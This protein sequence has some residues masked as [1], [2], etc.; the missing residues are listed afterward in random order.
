MTLSVTKKHLREHWI[1]IACAVLAAV[2]IVSPIIAFRFDPS[3]QGIEFFGT[4][5]ELNYVAQVH[6]IYNGNFKFGNVFFYEGQD[7]PYIRQS[8]PAILTAVVG[9]VL[10]LNVPQAIVVAKVVFPFITFLL[11]Y[12]LVFVLTRRRDAS[13]LG[14][15]FV[16]LSPATTALLD[17]KVWLPLISH[18]A[19]PGSDPQFLHYAR[20]INPQVSN[21]FFF[22]YLLTIFSLWY[23]NATQT[24]RR[25]II[26][27]AVATLILGLSFYTYLFTFTLL[28]A[29]SGI[30]WLIFLLRR[31]WQKLVDLTLIGTGGL[32]IGIP[33]YI[34][35][36]QAVHSTHWADLS[37]RVGQLL[38]HQPLISRVTLGVAALF[39]LLHRKLDAFGIFTVALLA[40]VFLV[41]NQQIITGRSIPIPQHYHWY[42]MAPLAGFILINLLYTR[43]QNLRHLYRHVLTIL[44]LVVFIGVA[45]AFQAWSYRMQQAQFV[46]IQPYGPALS[47]LGKHTTKED[48]VF[49]QEKLADLVVGY[50]PSNIYYGG[51]A[52]EFLVP[53]ERLKNAFFAYM[54]LDGV[55]AQ[56]AD[57]YFA[58]QANQTRFSNRIFGNYYPAKA[59]CYACYPQ[60]L[61]AQFAA[62]Y[63]AFAAT[64]LLSNLNTYRLTYALWDRTNNPNWRLERYFGEPVYSDAAIS[65]YRVVQ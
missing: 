25:R 4:D 27:V 19:F 36:Y 18:G 48:V 8:L 33:Y 46:A 49:A 14:A 57:A 6:A 29:M 13:L 34:N 37:V 60:E 63:R 40:G 22:G 50:T 28:F 62:E 38:T 12:A 56:D 24:S 61:N 42:Y 53:T 35:M 65:I 30:L 20:P 59:G 10:F 15:L 5:G 26:L 17:P 47:W 41:S 52:G 7:E 23:G 58:D 1:A 45:A 32:I 39:V 21:L 11:V 44:M 55:Q 31:D 64:P 2:I 9:K 16:L 3:Y 51:F 43:L 54:Y